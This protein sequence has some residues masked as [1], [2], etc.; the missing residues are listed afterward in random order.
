[1]NKNSA[2]KKGFVYLVGA[3]PGD[4]G[5]ITVKGRECIGKADVILYDYLAHKGL[6]SYAP[7]EAELIYAG[8]VGG[9]HNREQWQIN[10]M[11]VNK[12]LAGNIVVRLKGGDPFVFGRGGEECEALVSAGIPF[13]I[14]PGITSGIAAPAYA[15]IPLTH[16]NYTTSVAFVTGHESHDKDASEIDWERLSLGSGTLVFYMGMKN[17]SH[18]TENLLTH[19]RPPE[20]PVALIRW[21]TRPEQDVLTGTLADIAS[22]ARKAAFKPPAITIIGEVVSLREKLRWFDN[23]PLSGKGILVTRASEQSGEFSRLLSGHGARVFECPAI[24][25]VPPESY[26]GLDQAIGSLNRFDWLIFTSHNALRHFFLRL[27]ALGLDSR[28]LA[29]C[30]V[31]SVGP[32]TAAELAAFG[33]K[34][35]LVPADYKAEGV[36]EAFGSLETNGKRALF[37]RSDRA[38]DIIPVGLRKLGMEVEDPIAYRNVTPEKMP[39]DIIEALEGKQIHCAA[40]TSSS[41]IENLAVM[42]GENRLLHLL[43]GVAVAAI[44]PITSSACRDLG[45]KVDIEPAEYTMER[46]TDEIVRYFA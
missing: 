32:K 34:A 35:D 46:L 15:G 21:G 37:P 17:L 4:P 29:T 31:C 26:E 42:I 38:R 41:S 14:V 9:A 8:K 13:E 16:R 44:G 33:I 39:Q 1:M 24:S 18:I 25:I 11:L 12:A 2:N 43:E 10:E 40:F 19:G 30:K 23:R 22:K 27:H 5:L 36:V 45:L 20:T 6:L 3:G 28:A 7:T